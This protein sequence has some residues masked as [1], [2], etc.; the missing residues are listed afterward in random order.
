MSLPPSELTK[1]APSAV[2][3]ACPVDSGFWPFTQGDAVRAAAL[4][5][6]AVRIDL[7]SPPLCV[8]YCRRIRVDL[9]P[10][11]RHRAKFEGFRNGSTNARSTD[12]SVCAPCIRVAR[13]P[14][15]LVGKHESSGGPQPEDIRLRFVSEFSH[16]EIKC[17][18]VRPIERAMRVPRMDPQST[19]FRAQPC[20][21]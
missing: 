8:S 2:N 16:V 4:T 12:Y 3:S 9:R 5:K 17:P 1:I 11:I 14:H 21:P 19:V 15:R 20:R 13:E 10:F 18:S 7:I 6:I